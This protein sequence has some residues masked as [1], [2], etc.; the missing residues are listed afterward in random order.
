MAGKIIKD[1]VHGYINIEDDFIGILNSAEFQRLKFIEQSSFRVLY[2]SARHDR[3]VHS[4]G[5]YH[6]ATLFGERFI[7]NIKED[8]LIKTDYPNERKTFRYAALTHDIGHAP[9]SHTTED[10][11]KLRQTKTNEPYIHAELQEAVCT[12]I[13]GLHLK[14]E[15]KSQRIKT[16]TADFAG[17]SAKPHE[18]ISAILSIRLGEEYLPADTDCDL[19]LAARMITGCVYS[20]ECQDSIITDIGIRNCFICLLNSSA[21]DVDKLD[22]ITRD[23]M[24]TGFNTVTVDIK[25]LAG[26]VTAIKDEN[27]CIRPAFRKNALSVID[28]VFRAKQEQANWI[29]THPVVV[30][31]SALLTK[32]VRDIWPTDKMKKIFS[33]S[34]LG[35]RGIVTRFYS[36][37][38]GKTKFILFSDS[39]LI[40]ALKQKTDFSTECL[41]NEIFDRSLRRKPVWKSFF[42]YQYLFGKNNNNFFSFFKPLIDYLDTSLI[43]DA[44]SYKKIING[45]TINTTVKEAATFLHTFSEQEQTEFSFVLLPANSTFTPVIHPD[46]VFITFNNLPEVNKKNYMSYDELKPAAAE[47]GKKE[48]F[49]LYSRT[50][51]TK[52]QI[53]AFVKQFQR[54]TTS[55]P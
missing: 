45:K 48:F 54:K 13:K 40:F 34:S 9:F 8:L 35:K 16:F 10:F 26:S 41:Y 32:C 18:I 29:I 22:Y 43:L 24:M 44:D 50:K 3:F 27:D 51:L 14:P 19:E 21:V 47:T 31:E 6:L 2:P 20:Y 53:C 11:F 17:N 55:L 38:K 25:R 42:E 5:T 15:E 46:T 36:I 12:Y 1:S 4:L 23:T 49:Y 7:S 30:Y 33:S 37:S 39:D 28:N 52:E